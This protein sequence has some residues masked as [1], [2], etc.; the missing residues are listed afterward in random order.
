MKICRIA[1]KRGLQDRVHGRQN[2]TILHKLLTYENTTE[3][4]NVP[5]SLIPA[6]STA[7]QQRA[8]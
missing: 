3:L 7:L 6:V 8:V 4:M 2:N 5:E 1:T